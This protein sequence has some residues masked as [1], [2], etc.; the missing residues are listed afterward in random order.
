MVLPFL[1]LVGTV[2]LVVTT[3]YWISKLILGFLNIINPEKQIVFTIF[4]TLL[5]CTTLILSFFLFNL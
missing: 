1:I 2:S 3:S 5:I 4:T